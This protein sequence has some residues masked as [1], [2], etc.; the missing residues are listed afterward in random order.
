MQCRLQAVFVSFCAVL[1]LWP[2]LNCVEM[3]NEGFFYLVG[4]Y[5]IYALLFKDCLVKCVRGTQV[6]ER[7]PSALPLGCCGSVVGLLYIGSIP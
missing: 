2:A 1:G 3:G 4:C 5:F 6:E 7:Q